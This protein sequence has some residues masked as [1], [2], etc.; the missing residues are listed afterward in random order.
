MNNIVNAGKEIGDSAIISTSTAGW[1][2]SGASCLSCLAGCLTGGAIVS[3]LYDK[4]MSSNFDILRK[5]KEIANKLPKKG[6]F[7]GT[8]VEGWCNLLHGKPKT[9]TNEL[10]IDLS[11]NDDSK[12]FGKNI[13]I[14]DL[15][16]NKNKR[17]IN[18][19]IKNNRYEL[20][21]DSYQKNEII[22]K[23]KQEFE[24]ELREFN[25]RKQEIDEQYK[26]MLEKQEEFNKQKQNWKEEKLKYEEEE[27]IRQQKEKEQQEE[28]Y[29]QQMNLL[30]KKINEVDLL[31]KSNEDNYNLKMQQINKENQLLDERRISLFKQRQELNKFEEG[32]NEKQ[33][34]KK[35]KMEEEK[36]KLEESILRL[37]KEKEE[38]QQKL[39][40]EK[41]RL[42]KE[43]E[44]EM[45]KIQE[46]VLQLNINKLKYKEEMRIYEENKRKR[47]EEELRLEKTKQELEKLELH[48]KKNEEYKLNFEKEKLKREKEEE[49][50]KLE[51]EKLRLE[52]KEQELENERKKLEK[53]E[54]KLNELTKKLTFFEKAQNY[55]KKEEV[56]NNKQK[57]SN[58]SNISDYNENSYSKIQKKK[59]NRK[60]TNNKNSP[61]GIL[62]SE[63][64]GNTFLSDTNNVNKKKKVLNS[65]D[66]ANSNNNMNNKE[67]EKDLNN[68]ISNENSN[69]F[70]PKWQKDNVNKQMNVNESKEGIINIQ[71]HLN[72]DKLF[73]KISSNKY[74]ENKNLYLGSKNYQAFLETGIDITNNQL[75]N[76]ENNNNIDT[77]GN[78]K[79]Q[80]NNEENNN[81]T[82]NLP[83]INEKKNQNPLQSTR[84]SYFIN[85]Y[86][87]V[88]GGQIFWKNNKGKILREKDINTKN[89]KGTNTNNRSGLETTNNAFYGLSANMIQAD[90]DYWYNQNRQ[91]DTAT[92]KNNLLNTNG[93]KSTDT[94]NRRTPES[95]YNAYYNY[96]A[97][98][99]M[100]NNLYRQNRQTDTVAKNNNLLNKT[101]TTHTSN[102]KR[103]LS[104]YQAEISRPA[105]V[106]M[107]EQNGLKQNPQ[108]YN[109]TKNNNLLIKTNTTN[110]GKNKLGVSTTYRYDYS[111]P[112]KMRMEKQNSVKQNIGQSGN[113]LTT[114]T[115]TKTT[116]TGNN[117]LGMSTMS[118]EY[119]DAYSDTAKMRMGKQNGLELG[120]N[121]MEAKRGKINRNKE[122]HM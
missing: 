92:K 48:R 20:S 31:L 96:T 53:K 9:G 76:S 15:N 37:K 111:D 62:D 1:C 42:Q 87:E 5:D 88:K 44:E 105:E 39:E 33:K 110:T 28:Y 25:I 120:Y 109:A 83:K 66:K 54:L 55:R 61:S 30:Q 101:N 78:N 19:K 40:E 112:A 121:L 16:N 89:I 99:A 43:K 8:G 18:K 69:L 70:Y 4:R 97:N 74:D 7:Y 107:Q 11:H 117:K 71:F 73:K 122:K 108:P 58:I 34:E 10:D 102:N 103:L 3:A 49:K 95:T 82:T 80:H 106:R 118:T 35:Y 38:E 75:P 2:L 46:E 27:K 57:I 104:T 47:E 24:E 86:P 64:L 85:G 50:R 116:N 98:R 100:E 93:V 68:F 84:V 22:N 114:I 91:T 29:I 94:S 56:K 23:K 115:K 81:N 119:R 12:L 90:N 6:D 14:I 36:R 32:I 41:L 79:K 77:N 17:K 51:E 45:K 113:G 67:Y 65:F 13:N 26:K 60:K 63:L 59:E 72:K 52:K 21:L